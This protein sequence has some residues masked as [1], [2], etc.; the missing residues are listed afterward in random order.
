MFPERAWPAARGSGANSLHWVGNSSLTGDRRRRAENLRHEG[1][2]A[3]RAHRGRGPSFSGGLDRTR[4]TRQGG[5]RA[6]QPRQAGAGRA[7]PVGAGFGDGRG[8]VKIRAK[9][10]E[11]ADHTLKFGLVG[12]EQRIQRRLHL[13]VAMNQTT[14]VQCTRKGERAR[15][16]ST[17]S[18]TS[19]KAVA[20][21]GPG[22]LRRYDDSESTTGRG[23]MV[24]RDRPV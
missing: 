7:T 2:A 24:L 8:Y 9:L 22:R 16:S 3:G 6:R 19:P 10:L 23:A 14:T 1:V 18:S 13:R 15:S 11:R 12:T 17:R 5:H 21:S 20:G 4:R